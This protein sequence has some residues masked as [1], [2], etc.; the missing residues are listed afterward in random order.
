MIVDYAKKYIVS[1]IGSIPDKFKNDASKTKIENDVFIMWFD[2][3]CEIDDDGRMPKEWII[4][5]SKMTDKEVIAGMLRM[6]FKY[7]RE[8]KGMGFKP[9]S[10]ENYRGGFIGCKIKPVDFVTDDEEEK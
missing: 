4:K 1:G 7:N 10:K 3:H 9:F 5:E 6:G 8:L 2:E